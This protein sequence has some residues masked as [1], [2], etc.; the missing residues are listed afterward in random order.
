MAGETGAS[1]DRGVDTTDLVFELE[2]RLRALEDERAVLRTLFAYGYAIDYGLEEEFVDCWT[3][4]A[5]LVWSKTSHR[6]FPQFP[7]RC[8]TGREAIR[9][10]FQGQTHAPGEYHKHLLHQ[11]RIT[12]TGDRATVQSGFSRIDE[13]AVR[14]LLRSFGRYLDELVRCADGRWRFVRREAEV[15]STV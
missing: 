8:Y 15:E 3:E 4:D 11:P 9:E 1:D 10:A 6:E 5:T 13:A 7:A 14:P 2:R 12:I